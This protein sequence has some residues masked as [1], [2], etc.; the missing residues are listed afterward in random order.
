M[1]PLQ[2]IVHHVHQAIVE[3]EQ[4]VVQL[5][6]AARRQGAVLDE[7]WL[8]Y[9]QQLGEVSRWHKL[10]MRGVPEDP[11]AETLAQQLR[12]TKRAEMRA[13]IRQEE[14]QQAE[15]DLWERALEFAETQSVE[16]IEQ[17]LRLCSLEWRPGPVFARALM[18]EEQARERASMLVERQTRFVIKDMQKRLRRR[19]T[20]A[21][22]QEVPHG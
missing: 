3:L 20:A 19:R 21:R 18:R 12:D 15:A 16:W 9:R 6:E 2:E 1:T 10:I 17:E 7:E 11:E 14:R 8:A 4:R 5:Q 13:Q 22:R